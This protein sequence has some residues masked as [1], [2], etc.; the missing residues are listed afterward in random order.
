MRKDFIIYVIPMLNIEGVVHGNQRTNL[1]GYD[2]NRRWAEPSPY[3]T[4]VIFTAKNLMRV[5]EKERKIVMACD[6][7]GHFQPIG[8]FMYCNS[9]DRGDGLG[10]AP[11]HYEA[12]AELRVVPYLLTSENK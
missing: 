8:T 3:I 12:S 7:H 4:P 10:V 2:L 11:A 5:I 9:W 6:M 1:A